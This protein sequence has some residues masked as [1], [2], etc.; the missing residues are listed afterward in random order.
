MHHLASKSPLNIE[1][2][3]DLEVF[4]EFLPLCDNGNLAT[5]ADNS[6]NCPQILNENHWGCDVPIV[7]WW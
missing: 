7:C 3:R 1:S 6:R 2:H 5:F 4:M